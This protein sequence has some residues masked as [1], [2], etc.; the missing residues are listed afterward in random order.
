MTDEE[1]ARKAVE[2]FRPLVHDWEVGKQPCKNFKPQM[3]GNE[4]ATWANIHECYRCKVG[5]VSFCENCYRD[6]HFGGYE[7]CLQED[8]RACPHCNGSGRISL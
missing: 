3:D 5:K 2:A 7:K 6:H 4:H 1:L 8:E